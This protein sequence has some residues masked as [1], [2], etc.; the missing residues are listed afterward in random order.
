M[1]H[2]EERA[3]VF[4]VAGRDPAEMFDPVEEPLD[5]V[6]LPVDLPII[7]KGLLL[8]RLP[9]PLPDTALLPAAEPDIDVVPMSHRWWQVAPGTAGSRNPQDRFRKSR[10]GSPAGH[11]KQ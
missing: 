2:R 5:P 7:R 9:Q 8:E 4:L 3:G 1:D 10:S 11:S 6:A